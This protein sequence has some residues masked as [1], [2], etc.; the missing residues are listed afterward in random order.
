LEAITTGSMATNAA[1][2]TPVQKRLLAENL[3]L[4]PLGAAAAGDAAA[5]KNQCAAK[6]FA[7]PTTL[8]MWNGWGVDATNGRF[9]SG[10]AAALTAADVPKLSLQW[11]FAFPN[12]TSAFAQ[13]A[14]AGG[15]VFVGSDNGFVYSLD[16]A[17][18]CVYWSY[19]A[20]AAI[21]TAMTIGSLGG[22]RHAVYFGDLKGNVHAIDA[23][24]AAPIWTRRADPHPL[25]RITGA[26]VLVEGR[27]YVP[28]ASLEEGAGANPTYECCTF[29][30]SL[31]V[32]DAKTG[33]Q[34]WQAYTIANPAKPTTQ[35]ASGTQLWG[36]AGAAV[37]S[38]PTVDVRRG[39]V[40][41][42]TG[43]GYNEPAA[44]T[45]DSVIA[46]DLETGARLWVNQV[47]PNDAYMVSCG[48]GAPNRN[49]CPGVNGPDFDFGNSP[50]LRELP[51][52]KGVLVVGQK[53]GAVWALDPDNKGAV[54]WQQR[55]GRGSTLGGL[56]WG[57]AAD[58]ELGYFP[59][60]DA[61]YGPAQAGGMFALKLA[62]GE[63]AW[64]IRPPG[65]DCPP[66]SRT[67]TAARS[68]AISVIPGVVFSGTTDG[69]MRAYSTTDGRVVWEFNTAREF[70][71][72]NGV[73][74]KGGSIN[75]PGPV[76]AGGLLLTNSGYSYLG[77]GSAGNVLLAF[78]VDAG[79]AQPGR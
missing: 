11:A 6:P 22:S 8:P 12:G 1:Q 32:Y 67:C 24:T 79:A 28:V 74:G 39:A 77:T 36:P 72:V 26:P 18:G 61:Q 13:P 27:L 37:W 63:E 73:A 47:T 46:F 60:A 35:T 65:A 38:A 68:A 48:A 62:S 25:T 75:G 23:E 15:R 10:A 54:L 9:Q 20:P 40:Y 21:R 55:V 70:S 41:V 78:S 16:A 66:G 4:R 69:M 7:D 5:M 3:T 50:I 44:D 34:I 76:I 14:L 49:N 30:G 33:D 43:N 45:T 59:I 17:S 57:S 51:N 58:S 52:G 19:R 53:S 71:T 29:R 2:L 31:V 56:E 64:R 42:A